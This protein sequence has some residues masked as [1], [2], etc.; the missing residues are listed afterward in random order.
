MNAHHPTVSYDSSVSLIRLTGMV[1]ILLCHLFSWLGFAALSQLFSAGVPLFL[2]ISGFL[3]GDKKIRPISFFPNRYLRL[4]LPIGVFILILSGYLVLFAADEGNFETIPLY[5]LNLQGVSFLCGYLPYTELCGGTGHLWFITALMFC[6]LCMTAVKKV[7][8]RFRLSA[9]HRIVLLLLSC[10]AVASLSAVRIY[11][12]YLQIFF[13]GY[14][15]KKHSWQINAKKWFLC[16]IVMLAGIAVRLLFVFR[17][18]DNSVW[19]LSVVALQ[20]NMLAFWVFAAYRLVYAHR[21][22]WI[23]NIAQNKGIK[24]MDGLSF[25]IYIVHYIFLTEPFNVSRLEI[26]RA[27][28]CIVFLLASFLCSEALRSLTI[29]LQKG[30]SALTKQKAAAK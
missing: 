30:I 25:Y 5:L 11:L 21:T 15:C 20:Q 22:A 10:V 17:G 7:E 13:V 19:Y 26:G 24:H 27:A 2:L 4:T 9:R 12:S 3:Y 28:E 6:Y 8:H 23:D 14:A 29:L 1:F 18:L 16:T